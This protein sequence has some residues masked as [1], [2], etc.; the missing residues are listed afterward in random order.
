MEGSTG[1][2]VAKVWM[3]E[4]APGVNPLPTSAVLTVEIVPVC[5]PREIKNE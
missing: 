1:G 5:G 3:A 2:P 4:E